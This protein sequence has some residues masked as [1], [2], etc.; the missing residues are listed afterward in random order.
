MT[1][2]WVLGMA[3]TAL[4]GAALG[5][6][7]PLQPAVLVALL[8]AFIPYV[9]ATWHTRRRPWREVRVIIVVWALA[10]R[11]L[12]LAAP[13]ALS[14]DAYRYH[15][16]GTVQR[17]GYNPLTLAPDAPVLEPLRDQNWDQTDHREVSSAY[18]PLLLVVFRAGA[19]L[20][21]EAT[22]FKWIFLGF[23]LATWWMLIGWLRQ[24]GQSET[25]S[26]IWAWNPLVILEFAGMGHA[27]SLG[28]FFL[29]AG[30]RA[31][32]ALPRRPLLA[33]A[34]WTAALFAQ[35]FALP[36]IAGIV[37][38]QRIRRPSFWLVVLGLGAVLAWPFLDGGLASGLGLVA[39]GARWEFNGSLFPL[40][41]RLLDQ[42]PPIP[43][44]PDTW[45]ADA[46]AKLAAAGLLVA[47][48]L[49]CARK[50]RRPVQAARWML[51]GVLLLSPTVHP[52]YLAWLVALLVIEL[53]PA[54]L[55]FSA[56]V[57][58]SYAARLTEVLDGGWYESNLVR[59]LEYLPVYLLLA[60][61][62]IQSGLTPGR[63]GATLS[64]SRI[65]SDR[66]RPIPPGP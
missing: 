9:L 1:Y 47:V 57:L 53:R 28:I 43:V 42:P 55:L 16:E 4:L 23:D 25:A 3:L 45:L 21:D 18:P 31:W 30:L 14:N 36:I 50:A 49:V 27:M 59:W 64:A 60:W 11:G 38:G 44:G 39:F 6:M 48:W 63:A 40:L 62:L 61:G 26:L 46:T 66:T 65:D 41:A 37:A 15:W 22:V 13:Y 29:V 19:T 17:A 10:A 54:W 7:V 56:T 20:S 12:M 32:E 52:W 2:L 5:F 8:L 33:A 34:A 58:V 24:R 51:G 35:F